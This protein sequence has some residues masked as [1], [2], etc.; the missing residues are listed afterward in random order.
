MSQ[1]KTDKPSID[2]GSPS[3][4]PAPFRR[5]SMQTV[6]EEPGNR[7]VIFKLVAYT[8]MMIMAPVLV[9][10]LV[11]KHIASFVDVSP[12]RAYLYGA[13]ASVFTVNLL[14]VAYVVS[15]FREDPAPHPHSD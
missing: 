10:F 3:P 6:M 7:A 5:P 8:L 4:A 9:Y 11:N 15:A 1:T 13:G 12:E 2:N 14:I